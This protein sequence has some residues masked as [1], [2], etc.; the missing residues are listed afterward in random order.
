MASDFE[1]IRKLMIDLKTVADK[2]AMVFDYSCS[3][4]RVHVLKEKKF[5]KMF[6]ES[7]AKYR[8]KDSG[9]DA[10]YRFKYS[11]TTSGIEFFYLSEELI[12]AKNNTAEEQPRY[13]CLKKANREKA[14]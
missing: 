1:T 5:W 3:G 10:V 11:F 4:L 2:N 12:D 9:P 6:E 8:M 14:D 13:R 7:G